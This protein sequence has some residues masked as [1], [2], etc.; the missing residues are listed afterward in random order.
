M[1]PLGCIFG[2]YHLMGVLMSIGRVLSSVGAVALAALVTF[3]SASAAP[4]PIFPGGTAIL[5]GN[6]DYSY[7]QPGPNALTS[8]SDV[9]HFAY[10]S[11]SV[12]ASDDTTV[13]PKFSVSPNSF[14]GFVVAWVLGGD[15]AT[16]VGGTLLA[17]HSF[18]DGEFGTTLALPL[19]VLTLGPASLYHLVINWEKDAAAPAVYDTVVSTLHGDP[20]PVPLP[21]AALLFMSALAGLGLMGRRRM[22]ANR[23]QKA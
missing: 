15:P 6:N 2:K 1:L 5:T 10:P 17:F 3:G 16:A 14:T 7:T 19:P 11:L 21:P 13:N 22:A 4:I 8:G 9:F 20:G 23:Q 18:A 12:S